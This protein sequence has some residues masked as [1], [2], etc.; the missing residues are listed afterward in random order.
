M[1]N[2]AATPFVSNYLT[3]D[4]ADSV[5]AQLV[6]DN[7]LM[8]KLYNALCCI[9]ED[10][11]DEV[12]NNLL[13]SNIADRSSTFQFYNALPAIIISCYQQVSMWM[14]ECI[15]ETASL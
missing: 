3:L 8:C 2:I 6:A 9:D 14:A 4:N 1:S 12:F 5:L 10:A 7:D 15:E 11:F 13:V